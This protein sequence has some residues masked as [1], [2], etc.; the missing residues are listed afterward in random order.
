MSL[1]DMVEGWPTVDADSAHDGWMDRVMRGINAREDSEWSEGVTDKIKEIQK[2]AGLEP[3]GVVSG[4]TWLLLMPE[5]K[6]GELNAD[7]AGVR[8]ALEVPGRTSYFDDDLEGI[9]GGPVLDRAAWA[10]LVGLRYT[11]PVV[12]EEVVPVVAETAVPKPKSP[13][14][15]SQENLDTQPE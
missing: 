12:V 6:K 13:E 9:V 14:E 3:T 2:A 10:K 4:V 7:L 1:K 11:E 5:I 15:T 8:V